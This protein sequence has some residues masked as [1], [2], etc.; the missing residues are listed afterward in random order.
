M[1]GV[2][3]RQGP[4]T[5]GYDRPVRGTGRQHAATRRFGSFAVAL[6][7]LV[8]LWLLSSWTFS[9]DRGIGFRDEG[10]YLLAADPPT[11][12]ARWVTPFGWHTAPF[13]RLVGHDVADLRTFAIWALV[14]AGTWLGW[15]IGRRLTDD[16]AAPH[17][18]RIR[19]GLALVGALGA[20]LLTSSFLRTPGYNWVNL[21]GLLIAT[22]GALLAVMLER[23][24]T[25]FWRSWRAHGAAAALTFGVWF[26]VPAKPSTAPLFLAAAAVFVGAHLRRRTGSFALLSTAWGLGWTALGLL[27]GWW[28]TNF[29]WVLRQ[30]ASFPPLDRNQTVRGALIDVLRTPKVAWKDLALLRPTTILLM[31]IAAAIAVVAFRIERAG[32]DHVAHRVLRVAPL[33]ISTV[34]AVGTAV[35]WPLLGPPTPF[36]R[37]DWYGT[38]NAAVLL[39]VGGLLHVVAN[40]RRTDATELRRGL[41]IAGL[42]IAAVF[43]FG[44]GS[45]MS[46]YHQAALAAAL[47]W[48]AAAAVVVT[49]GGPRLRTGSLGVVV[50]ASFVML[51][52]NT[53]DSRHHP[54]DSTDIATQTTPTRFGAHGDELLLDPSTSQFLEQLQRDALT[55]GFCHGDRLIGMAW[56]WT[57][58][59]AFALG[60]T[61]NEHLVMTIFGY[62]DASDVLDVT[63]HDLDDPPW[64]DAWVATSDP[65]TITVAQA[66]ELRSALDRLPGANGRAFPE[67]YVLEVDVDGFQLWRPVTVTPTNC[68]TR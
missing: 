30:S 57:S 37:F 8:G 16:G 23:S 20:P 1:V 40:W 17:Q 25:S 11:A 4:L 14:L 42:C 49:V 56:G 26:T 54:F 55:A 61:V 51:V 28:P 38:T 5:H 32:R 36:S 19:W 46:I 53:V 9:T 39:F 15:T 44:F 12:T 22:T 65:A 58:T 3:Q 59:T 63:I 62:P 31:I 13:F 7:S 47:M 6:A 50:A 35:P 64:R 29:L 21:V 66:A 52:S 68:A 34:A 48:C 24:T 45:A 67:D 10:L 43:V 33:L 27:A 60:A 18:A 41:A 2:G